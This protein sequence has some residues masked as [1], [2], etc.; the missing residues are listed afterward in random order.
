M[1]KYAV[2]YLVLMLVLMPSEN[3]KDKHWKSKKQGNSLKMQINKICIPMCLQLMNPYRLKQIAAC[4][5]Q[6]HYLQSWLDRPQR[7]RFDWFQ[8]FE[9]HI[10]CYMKKKRLQ[11]DLEM[12]MLISIKL[13]K[14]TIIACVNYRWFSNRAFAVF[15]NVFKQLKH[16]AACFPLMYT[17]LYPCQCPC[18]G[19]PEDVDGL[20]CTWL[21][22]S[23]ILSNGFDIL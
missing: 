13:F 19:L 10:F 12:L 22:L 1:E 8:Y 5:Y 14:K 23:I 11:Y 15:V 9:Y 16:F 21:L 6:Y 2:L 20:G 7:L 18:I 17:F 3:P 4:Q